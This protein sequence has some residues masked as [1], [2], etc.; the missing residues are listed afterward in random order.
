[1]IGK[2]LPVHGL[3]TQ[4]FACLANYLVKFGISTKNLSLYIACRFP[5]IWFVHDLCKLPR[6]Q[7]RIIFTNN[8]S[9]ILRIRYLLAQS[10]SLQNSESPSL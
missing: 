10:Y 6:H 3:A 1:M 2:P 5:Q 8:V 9:I 7:F 4:A